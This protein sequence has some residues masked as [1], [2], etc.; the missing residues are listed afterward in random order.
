MKTSEAT[1]RNVLVEVLLVRK[2]RGRWE[3]SR[4]H[5]YI[6]PLKYL[7]KINFQRVLTAHF[8]DE[9]LEDLRIEKRR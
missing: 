4:K 2:D 1:E 7:L 6:F 8:N 9:K 5:T 3:D